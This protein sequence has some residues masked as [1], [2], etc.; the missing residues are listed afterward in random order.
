LFPV[1]PVPLSGTVCGLSAA[2]SATESV[3]LKSPVWL[4]EKVTLT[5]QIAP[6]ARVGL[7]VLVS[8]KFVLAVMLVMLSV[9]V[10]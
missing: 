4:G 9:A 2:L 3:P 1:K 5:V 6:D 8:P 7:Q 10:P